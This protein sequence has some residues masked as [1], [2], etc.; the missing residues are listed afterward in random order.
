MSSRLQAVNK[1]RYKINV[2]WEKDGQDVRIKGTVHMIQDKPTRFNKSVNGIAAYV[3]MT[4]YMGIIFNDELVINYFMNEAS[5]YMKQY[6]KRINKKYVKPSEEEF[7][8]YSGLAPII[9]YNTLH[10]LLEQNIVKK[11]TLIS[12]EP[13][14]PEVKNFYKSISFVLRPDDDYSEDSDDSDDSIDPYDPDNYETFIS[15][16]EKVL[17]A[18][19]KKWKKPSLHNLRNAVPSE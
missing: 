5:P 11:S 1:N 2:S 19:L 18:C 9:L 10:T 14:S 13:D 16:V 12:V 4:Y 17:V 8:A 7:V 3:D 15:T 6:K